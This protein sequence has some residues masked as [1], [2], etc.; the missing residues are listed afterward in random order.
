MSRYWTMLSS[1]IVWSSVGSIASSSQLTCPNSA[2]YFFALGSV[3]L[4]G[5]GGGVYCSI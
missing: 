4:A 5:F 1:A 2:M 3:I